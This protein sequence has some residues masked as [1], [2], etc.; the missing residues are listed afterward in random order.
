MRKLVDFLVAL[1]PLGLLGMALIDSAGVPLPG[2]VDATLLLIAVLRPETAWWS[3]GAA[4]VGSVLGN[5]ILFS[6][7]QKG[8]EAYLDQHTRSG[9][10]LTLRRWFVR[11]GLVTVFIPALL[12][13]PLPMKIPVFCTAV[14]GVSRRKFLAVIAAARLPHYLALAWL[15]LQLGQ[16]AGAWLKSHLWHLSGFAVGLAAL[17]FVLVR[18]SDRGEELNAR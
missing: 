3:A 14:F 18:L 10:G 11:Y 17:L 2:G 8:G 7:A 13:I 1:G 12:P 6:L 15:G 9:R 5:A 16:D 4:F